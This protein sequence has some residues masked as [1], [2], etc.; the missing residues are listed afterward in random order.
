MK[1]KIKTAELMAK[2]VKNGKILFKGTICQC[3]Q[4]RKDI[5]PDYRLHSIVRIV[6]Y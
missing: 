1:S 5:E 4:K 3:I 2:I 6:T